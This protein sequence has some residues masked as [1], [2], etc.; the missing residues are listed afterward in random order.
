MHEVNSSVEVESTQEEAVS[1]RRS[2]HE[3]P[4]EHYGWLS[5]LRS[6]L[7]LDPLIWMYTLVLGLVAL[8]GGLFD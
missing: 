7:V 2:P 5:R 8:P 3:I 4:G 1:P 6:Y